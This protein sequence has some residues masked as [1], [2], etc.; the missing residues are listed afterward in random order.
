MIVALSKFNFAKSAITPA[1]LAK[2]EPDNLS[3]VR[4]LV[5]GHHGR[6]FVDEDI[7]NFLD[8]Q[9]WYTRNPKFSNKLLNA[10]ERGNLDL[11]RGAEATSHKRAEPGDLRFWETREI[12]PE[13]LKETKLIDLHVMSSEIEAIHG[14]RFSDE[15][16][17]QTYFDER[18]WYQ[19]SAKYDP[20]S[21]SP[22][23]AAT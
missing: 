21:L 13:T 23:N 20:N 11:I 5:F 16:S 14:K 10:T 12:M 6:V 2:V 15:P 22:P 1:Q 18:Y 8:A 17:M 4:G 9:S 7:Q 19:P 3:L